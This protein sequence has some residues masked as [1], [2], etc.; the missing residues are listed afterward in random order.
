MPVPRQVLIDPI[1]IWTTLLTI[2]LI[3]Q[4]RTRQSNGQSKDMRK[5]R[6]LMGHWT[7]WDPPFP[8]VAEHGLNHVQC[9]FLL[10]PTTIDWTD[11][12]YV[13]THMV[14]GHPLTHS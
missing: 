6:E 11:E 10:A 7:K 5:V 4:L 8:D 2:L 9:T 14:L 13:A 3:T 12:E 1:L